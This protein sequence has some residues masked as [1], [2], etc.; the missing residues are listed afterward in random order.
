LLFD[1]YKIEA[2]PELPEAAFL[3]RKA[4]SDFYDFISSTNDQPMTARFTLTP[5]RGAA[6]D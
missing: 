2:A 6:R 5:A 4:Q 3:K 1:G